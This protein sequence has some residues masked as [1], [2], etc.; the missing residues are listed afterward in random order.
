MFAYE[1]ARVSGV[2]YVK[3]V[4]LKKNYF[5]FFK[6]HMRKNMKCTHE[7]YVGKGERVRKDVGVSTRRGGLSKQKYFCT[8][9]VKDP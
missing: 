3:Y 4:S 2:K 7:M 1:R 9:D 6:S 5:P 8:Y